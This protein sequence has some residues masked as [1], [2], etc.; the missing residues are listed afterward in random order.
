LKTK[1]GAVKSEWRIEDGK[2]KY[3][4]TI[5]ENTTADLYLGN[6]KIPLEAGEYKFEV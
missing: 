5:P 2:F 3:S 6:K 1:W 4:C